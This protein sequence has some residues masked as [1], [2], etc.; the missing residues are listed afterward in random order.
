M[1][2]RFYQLVYQLI[3]CKKEDDTLMMCRR[4][5]A[6]GTEGA[7]GGSAPPT[8]NLNGQGG[9]GRRGPPLP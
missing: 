4:P 2:K 1:Q 5:E 9:V 3:I 6:G 7:R 8:E